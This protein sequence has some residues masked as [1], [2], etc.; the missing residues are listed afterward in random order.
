MD[1]YNEFFMKQDTINAKI[2]ALRHT[3]LM[4]MISILILIM[5]TVTNNDVDI[6]FCIVMIILSFFIFMICVVNYIFLFKIFKEE[7]K[8]KF[9]KRIC[10]LCL[11]ETEYTNVILYNDSGYDICMD[12]L[13]QT[14]IGEFFAKLKDDDVE[15]YYKLNEFEEFFLFDEIEKEDFL[16]FYKLQEDVIEERE[17]IVEEVIKE[18][19]KENQKEKKVEA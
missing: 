10:D 14:G 2:R 18:I 13:T 17:D 12:V 5:L 1:N 8:G 16:M 15:I 19:Q 6:Y 4:M 9:S 7:K 11:S 3:I